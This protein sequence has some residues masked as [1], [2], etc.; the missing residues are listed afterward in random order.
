M[1][2]TILLVGSGGFIGSILRFLVTRFIQM[3]YLTLFPWGTMTVNIIGS[4]IIGIV[5]GLSEKGDLLG[6]QARFFL[7]VGFC[8]G[9]TTFSSLSY[10]AFLLLQNKEWLK[11]LFYTTG[12]F[13]SGLAAVVGGRMLVKA[14]LP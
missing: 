5:F 12:S 7:A 8:G 1:W 3:R 11:F 14:L 2:K 9:F 13:V 4:F 10:D 6:P